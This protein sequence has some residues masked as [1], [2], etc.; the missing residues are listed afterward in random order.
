MRG[1]NAIFLILLFAVLPFLAPACGSDQDGARAGKGTVAA[2]APAGFPRS[3]PLARKDSF[4]GL[5]FDLHPGATDTSLGA[6]I[7]EANIRDLLERVRPDFVQ[8][9]C[10]GHP[11][12]AGYPT[13][14]G[15][16]SPGIVNDSLA[17][18]R[19]ATREQGV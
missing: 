18:W 13:V 10:K 5:H 4:F 1:R 16:S 11:G 19:K 6:D 3:A 12:W 8:Y 14:V 7:S 15:W 17:V 2:S 9:D